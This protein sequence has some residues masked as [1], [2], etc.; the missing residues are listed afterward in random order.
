MAPYGCSKLWMLM[1][2]AELQRRLRAQG[3]KAAQVCTAV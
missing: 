2:G 3:G 1:F